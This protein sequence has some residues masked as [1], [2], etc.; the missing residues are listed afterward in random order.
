MMDFHCI[1]GDNEGF[2]TLLENELIFQSKTLFGDWNKYFITDYYNI[3][4][5]DI[6]KG[7]T[8]NT[9]IIE[10]KDKRFNFKN[11]ANSN[12]NTI[13]E[14]INE[15]KGDPNYSS[16]QKNKSIEILKERT[17]DRSKRSNSLMVVG[18]ILI[19]VSLIFWCMFRG[20]SF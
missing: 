14:F 18:A 13:I 20:C 4:F 10:T 6:E 19:F 5:I 8:A 1:Y 9:L 15:R 3:K 7:L 17:A 2:L 12:I 16:E 11:I